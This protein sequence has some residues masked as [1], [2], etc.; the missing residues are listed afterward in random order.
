MLDK[1]EEFKKSLDK[2]IEYVDVEKDGVK[3]ELVVTL[4]FRNDWRIFR[5]TAKGYTTNWEPALNVKFS[6]FLQAVE[7]IEKQ[8]YELVMS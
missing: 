8:G 1:V 6:S 2:R 7:F 5:M 4:C 3:T